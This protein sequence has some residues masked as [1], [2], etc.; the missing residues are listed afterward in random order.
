VLARTRRDLYR[1]LA[2][3]EDTDATVS[4]D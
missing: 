1:I 3:G 4:E 2:E